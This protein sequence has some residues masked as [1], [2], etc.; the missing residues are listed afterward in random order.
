LDTI[1]KD[2]KIVNEKDK[3]IVKEN[4]NDI[5]VENFNELVKVTD[6][7]EKTYLNIVNED[8]NKFI[9]Q[10]VEVEKLN[11][12]DMDRVLDFFLNDKM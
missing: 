12:F 6:K 1:V 9:T 7:K 5:V 8:L 4:V 10:F 3:E 2:L 11:C